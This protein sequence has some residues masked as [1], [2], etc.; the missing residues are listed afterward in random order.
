M[1]Y[2]DFVSKEDRVSL[3]YTTNTHQGGT[4]DFDP[5]KPVVVMYVCA[6]GLCF[7]YLLTLM[8]STCNT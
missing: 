5:D 1:P 3:W 7:P 8:P 6:V 4:S 2:I